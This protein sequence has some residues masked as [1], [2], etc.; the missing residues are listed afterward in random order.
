MLNPACSQ[1]YSSLAGSEPLTAQSKE[2]TPW[3]PVPAGNTA[4]LGPAEGPPG[5]P[6]GSQ[7]RSAPGRLQGLPHAGG[8]SG[9]SVPAER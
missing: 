3:L 9:T 6:A 4:R 5:P 1:F 7:Q 8:K 2:P